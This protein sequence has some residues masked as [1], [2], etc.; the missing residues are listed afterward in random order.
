[1]DLGK[2]ASSWRPYVMPMLSLA[3][4]G[5]VLAVMHLQPELSNLI[6]G[7]NADTLMQSMQ[8]FTSHR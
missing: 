3:L 6:F 2:S 1:M 5:T 7:T 4:C 8:G